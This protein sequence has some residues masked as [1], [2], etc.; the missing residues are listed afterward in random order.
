MLSTLLELTRAPRRRALH[1]RRRRPSMSSVVARESSSRRSSTTA[2]RCGCARLAWKASSRSEWTRRTAPPPLDRLAVSKLRQTQRW[3]SPD[4]RAASRRAT[5]GRLVAGHTT[6][7]APLG[8]QHR[9]GSPRSSGFARHWHRLE[10]PD[11]PFADVPR[12][13]QPGRRIHPG[14]ASSSPRWSSPSDARGTSA[15]ALPSPLA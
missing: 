11:S 8:G 13:P 12:M 3:S 2:P 4:T 14:R 6:R 7:C 9:N 10:R 5:F 15:S 1:E